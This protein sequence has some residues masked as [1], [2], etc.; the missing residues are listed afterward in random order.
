LGCDGSLR[1]VPGQCRVDCEG[2]SKPD[3]IPGPIY[4]TDIPAFAEKPAHSMPKASKASTARV[5]L[6]KKHTQDVKGLDS[7]GM[8]WCAGSV[9]SSGGLGPIYH[10]R[11][12]KDMGTGKAALI[13]TA[14]RNRSEVSACGWAAV[15]TGSSGQEIYFKAIDCGFNWCGYPGA[16]GVWRDCFG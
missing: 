4:Q 16:K 11:R 13:G 15:A 12:E 3:E 7:P 1:Y 9:A 8:P 6:S 14:E 2:Q 5:Y 10:F